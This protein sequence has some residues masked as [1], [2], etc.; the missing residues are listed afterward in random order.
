MKEYWIVVECHPI[1]PI[2]KISSVDCANP[3]W[4]QA[5]LRIAEPDLHER[6]EWYVI[7][8]SVV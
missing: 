3:I 7:S 5:M 1:F 8:Q 4:P 6:V 2:A